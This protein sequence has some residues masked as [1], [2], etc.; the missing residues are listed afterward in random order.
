MKEI[1]RDTAG[2]SFVP[3]IYSTDPKSAAKAINEGYYYVFGYSRQL[4]DSIKVRL[5]G[6]RGK[7][8]ADI[9]K[10]F[11]NLFEGMP[12]REGRGMDVSPNLDK[13][14]T[15]WRKSGL[16]GKKVL[17]IASRSGEWIDQAIACIKQAAAEERRKKKKPSVGAQGVAEGAKNRGYAFRAARGLLDNIIAKREISLFDEL[18]TGGETSYTD[19]KGKPITLSPYQMKLV[20]AFAQVLDTLADRPDVDESIRFLTYEREKQRVE[21]GKGGKLPIWTK[22]GKGRVSAFIDIPALARLIYSVNHAGGKQVNKVRDEIANLAQVRQQYRIKQGKKTLI[23]GAPLIYVGKGLKVEEEGKGTLA[24]RVEILFEDIFL[25]ELK[26]KYSLAP[27]TIID[28]W[29][30]TGEN[31]ELFAMLLFLLQQERGMKVRQAGRVEAA[32]RKDLKKEKKPFKEIE[33]QAKAVRREALTYRETLPSIC[34]RLQG[35][36]VYCQERNGKIYL[37]KER[38][39]N[40]L[41]NATAAL[42][43]M[44]IISEYYETRNTSLELVCNFLINDKWLIEETN[45]MKGLDKTEETQAENGG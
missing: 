27:R 15:T 33:R 21:A 43:K 3:H 38:I 31:S 14:L 12:I 41:K 6:Y 23:L 9:E 24:N 40:D 37:R 32:V 35:R 13:F 19:M 22:E 2:P 34:E 30:E 28:R 10:D 17:L 39:M 45:K 18:P 36:K 4:Q 5:Y 44:G 29:N 1:E 42:I 20:M 11:L 25:Y 8:R 26:D 16:E 7:D